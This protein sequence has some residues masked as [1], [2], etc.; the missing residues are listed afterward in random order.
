MKGASA[1]SL[2]AKDNSKCIQIKKSATYLLCTAH[3]HTNRNKKVTK[4]HESAIDM[5]SNW[6]E[7][8]LDN[9]R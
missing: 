1:Q 8:T 2:L 9:Y 7:R 4:N 6:G 3:K 5:S